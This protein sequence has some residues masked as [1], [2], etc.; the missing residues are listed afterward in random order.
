MRKVFGVLLTTLILYFLSRTLME[1]SVLVIW[2]MF[3]KRRGVIFRRLKLM[4]FVMN[5]N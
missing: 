1:L 5:L 4:K 2:N 3:L